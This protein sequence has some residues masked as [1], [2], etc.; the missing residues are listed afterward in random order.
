M[1]TATINPL[2]VVALRC[3]IDG[4]PAGTRATVLELHSVPM[5]LIEI[6]NIDGSTA[7]MNGVPVAYLKAT[8]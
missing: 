2:D 8:R 4:W 6:T 3:T 7:Y 5:S 1:N